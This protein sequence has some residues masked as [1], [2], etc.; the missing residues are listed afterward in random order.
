MILTLNKLSIVTLVAVYL[1]ILVGGIV[2]STGSGMGCPDWPKC[3]GSWIPPTEE[4]QLPSSYQQVYVQQRAEKNERFARYLGA[5]GFTNLA[6]EIQHDSSILKPEDFNATKTW[7]EY[8]NRLLGAVVGALILAT[9]VASL[10]FLKK[11]RTVTIIAFATLITV[12]IQGWIGS[13][14]VSTNLLPW[15]ITVH[16][17]LALLIVALLTYLV[18]RV[19]PSHRITSATEP[20]FSTGRSHKIVGATLVMLLVLTLVQIVMGTQVRE[21]IN[22][23]SSALGE[24]QRNQ[25]IAGLDWVFYVHRSY[26]LVVL[27]GHLYLLYFLYKNF[28]ERRNL[29]RWA[30]VLCVVIIAEIITGAVMAYFAIPR[31]AQPLH[32]IFATLA[33][34]LQFYLLLLIFQP[35]QQAEHLTQKTRYV[36]Y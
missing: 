10:R 2:R 25:W 26:S 9:F 20:V 6:Q 8:L 11:D 33:F 4:S 34:G 19:S 29:M 1:L 35:K 13:V 15:M 21:S 27:A 22:E 32:L 18:V 30:K 17:L 3:F 5:L 12:G 31:L 36:S 24:A 14:V 16:M 28:R 23:V 7:I